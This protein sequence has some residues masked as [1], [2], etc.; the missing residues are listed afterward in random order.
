MSAEFTPEGFRE[1]FDGLVALIREEWPALDEGALRACAGDLGRTVDLIAAH[2]DHTKVK[3]RRDLGE[4]WTLAG[5]NGA[6]SPR[7]AL[8]ALLQKLEG[9]VE[10]AVGQVRAEVLPKAE[11]TVRDHLWTS[12]AI[13]AAV[14]FV[15][16]VLTGVSRR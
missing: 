13:A 8:D 2:S 3:V 4:L 14:G 15:L 9:K 5:G 11:D 6:S 1:R 10:K 12:L 7:A 16:G